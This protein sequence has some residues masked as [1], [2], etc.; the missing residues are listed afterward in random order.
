MKIKASDWR[1]SRDLLSSGTRGWHY[2]EEFPKL[3]KKH[4]PE[5]RD[6]EFGYVSA[7]GDEIARWQAMGWKSLNVEHFE[8][9]EFNK[10]VG[11]RFELKDTDG[12]LKIMGNWIMIRP[13]D[14]AAEQ[15]AMRNK[16]AE[17]YELSSIK[18]N[19]NLPTGITPEDVDSELE[20]K[21]FSTPK[22][23]PDD[24]GP[25]K[26]PGRPPGSKNRK[27]KG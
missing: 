15:Q 3:L 22:E 8:K 16:A 5:L 13:Y 27:K 18:A 2:Q 10:V 23:V 1:E 17:D 20:K 7:E 9:E 19:T 6:F 21:T 12:R 25:K 14:F 4:I 26:K 11:F 24:E